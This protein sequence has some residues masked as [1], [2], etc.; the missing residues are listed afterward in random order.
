M[1]P[2]LL[3]FGLLTAIPRRLL[4]LLCWIGGGFCT[5]YGLGDMIGGLTRAVDGAENAIWYAVLW[6]PIWLLG[7]ILYLGVAW[8]WRSLNQG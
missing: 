6:G 1:V 8:S 2:I 3:G 5:L 4:A 7:G